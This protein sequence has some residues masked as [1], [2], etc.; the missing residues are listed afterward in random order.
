MAFVPWNKFFPQNLEIICNKKLDLGLY[1]V[2]RFVYLW[3]KWKS[4][5]RRCS[6]L[7]CSNFVRMKTIEDAAFLT[8]ANMLNYL[9]F[10]ETLLL[11]EFHRILWNHGSFCVCGTHPK[12]SLFWS[13]SSFSG[14]I[15]PKFQ[16]LIGSALAIYRNF[17]P[18]SYFESI[19]IW[20]FNN[21]KGLVP[22]I[23]E[24]GF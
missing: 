2:C 17:E 4:H 23:Q 1:K 11:V 9:T 19:V 13:F 18:A 14:N 6:Q 24:L 15:L 16:N 3:L 20:V 12:N 10:S 21:A 5:L 8:F 7:S 22:R